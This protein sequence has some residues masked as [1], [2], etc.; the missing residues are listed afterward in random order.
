MRKARHGTSVALGLA[1]SLC[2]AVTVAAA[3]VRADR[4]AGRI[5]YS[6]GEIWLVNADGSGNRKRLTRTSDNYA[7]VVW[8]ADGRWLAFERRYDGP[9]R[10]C[11]VEVL[12]MR[13]DGRGRVRLTPSGAEDAQPDWSPTA[14]RIAFTRRYGYSPLG[15]YV[16][17]ADGTQA[18]RIMAN[19]SDPKWSPDGRKIAFSTAARDGVHVMN[20]DGTGARLV[21]GGLANDVSWS[22]DGTRLVFSRP[23]AR[24]TST[25]VV[26][27]NGSGL[28]RVAKRCAEA[29]SPAWSPDGRA[30]AVMCIRRAPAKNQPDIYT[31]NTD[32]THLRQITSN[33]SGD[34]FPA[35]SP[36]GRWIA[37]VGYR[38]DFDNGVWVVRSDGT[39]RRR[40]T[41]FTHD[42]VPSWEPRRN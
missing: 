20:A 41:P 13:S 24:A 36:D 2:L 7:P 26:N 3:D 1:G 31:V 22:P 34:Y 35:W 12:I 11:C 38:G 4:P 16:A 5:A 18:R 14:P 32:G 42:S 40:L 28:R 6:T 15:L 9:R 30:I 8:S 17:N 23:S 29:S 39:Q 25:F 37:Y 19:A 33:P 10:D 27:A 21:L